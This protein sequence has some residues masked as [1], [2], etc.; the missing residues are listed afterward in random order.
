MA[1]CHV[2]CNKC[3]QFFALT[4]T[5]VNYMGTIINIFQLGNPFGSLYSGRPGRN[6][7]QLLV[8]CLCLRS[9]FVSF[10][11]V[12][13]SYSEIYELKVNTET[14]CYMAFF[15]VFFLF[16]SFKN[17]VLSFMLFYVSCDAYS[18][19]IITTATNGILVLTSWW[20]ASNGGVVVSGLMNSIA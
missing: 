18:N 14:E 10:F 12:V 5:D 4:H 8:I 19:I 6:T 17:V 9:W 7:Y 2:M 20:I 16:L 11:S 15:H 3:C 13:P 1:Y